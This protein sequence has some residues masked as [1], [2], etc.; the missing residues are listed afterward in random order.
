MLC[1][2]CN[3]KHVEAFRHSHI[4]QSAEC[5]AYLCVICDLI[6]KDPADHLDWSEQKQ[7]YDTHSNQLGDA[8]YEKFLGQLVGPLLAALAL[9]SSELSKNQLRGLDWGSGPSNVLQQLIQ[10]E[11]LKMEIY[12]PVYQPKFPVGLFDFITCT[13]VVEHFQNPAQSFQEIDRLLKVGGLFAGLTS[14]HQGAKHFEN[15][16]YARD[17][18]HVVFYSEKTFQWIAKNWSYEILQLSS[19]IFVFKKIKNLNFKI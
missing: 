10:R 13:E 6:F 16:W 1:P 2:L 7:R 8:G 12:D 3:S 17:T 19:P 14:F 4:K 5:L 9:G 11:N 15:W 18:T